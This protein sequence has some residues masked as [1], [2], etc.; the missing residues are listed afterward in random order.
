[1]QFYVALPQILSRIS[2][3]NQ[4]VYEVLAMMII[5]MVA[6][7]PQQALWSLLAVAKSSSRDRAGR[8]ISLLNK[9]KV[10]HFKIHKIS[11]KSNITRSM[12]RGR[13]RIIQC[14]SSVP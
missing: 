13:A 11:D 14:L 8:G 7:H 3:P 12:A 1:M 9:L 10:S 5:K 2:H 6:T 4:K